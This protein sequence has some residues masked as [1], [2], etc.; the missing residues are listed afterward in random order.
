MRRI[1]ALVAASALA[2]AGCA[3]GDVVTGD[4]RTVGTVSVVFSARPARARVGQAVTLT[5]KLINS[6]GAERNIVFPQKRFYDFWADR[7]GREVWRWSDGRIFEQAAVTVTL[8]SQSPE[9]YVESWTP[10]EAGTYEVF[11]SV[12]SKEYERPLAGRVVVE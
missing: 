8:A 6:S 4:R 9:T 11:A 3:G 7:D 1:A 5:I 12:A 2:L 10:E